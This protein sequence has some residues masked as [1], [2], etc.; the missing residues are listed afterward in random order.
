MDPIR[1]THW[2]DEYVQISEV[3]G[4]RDVVIL[5]RSPDLAPVFAQSR[6]R[7]SQQYIS[8]TASM[9]PVYLVV[10]EFILRTDPYPVSL[11]TK[12]CLVRSPARRPERGDKLETES[13]NDHDLF[14]DSDH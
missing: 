9:T 6:Y 11:Q 13:S 1:A 4:H 14:T 10:G 12:R 8:D 3:T 7:N 2:A 5:S